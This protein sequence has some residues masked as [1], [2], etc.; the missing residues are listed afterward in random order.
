MPAAADAAVGE[1]LAAAPELA[2][3][4]AETPRRGRGVKG[5]GGR[6]SGGIGAGGRGWR[7]HR[8]PKL[9]RRRQRLQPRQRLTKASARRKHGGERAAD[10]TEADGGGCDAARRRQRPT[11]RAITGVVG[12]G[13][14]PTAAPGDNGLRGDPKSGR[15]WHSRSRGRRPSTSP[16]LDAARVAVAAAVTPCV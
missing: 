7:G 10:R 12:E 11:T 2:P 14:A 8:V 6:G 3:A 4:V 5:T 13:T 9:W 16:L 15:T 1:P